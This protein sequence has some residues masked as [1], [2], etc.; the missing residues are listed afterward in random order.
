MIVL[1]KTQDDDQFSIGGVIKTFRIDV[2]IR[3]LEL[4]ISVYDFRL[5]LKLE[6]ID[7]S[8]SRRQN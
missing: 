1:L 7:T 5:Q 8:S 4:A 6:K 2:V 3:C